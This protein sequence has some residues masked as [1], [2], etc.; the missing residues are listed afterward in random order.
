[1]LQIFRVTEGRKEREGQT[2]GMTNTQ[3]Q[4]RV[5]GSFAFNIVVGA[6]LNMMDVAI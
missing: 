4:S 5:K 3:G 6:T 1:M 2:E